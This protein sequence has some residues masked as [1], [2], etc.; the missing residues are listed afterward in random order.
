L[1]SVG[2]GNYDSFMAKKFWLA[3]ASTVFGAVLISGLGRATTLPPE[4]KAYDFAEAYYVEDG[5]VVIAP[6]A[7]GF[8][9]PHGVETPE[10]IRVMPGD[11]FVQFNPNRMLEEDYRFVRLD[12]SQAFFHERIFRYKVARD[13]R[14]RFCEQREQLLDT[15]DF[16]L[17]RFR[18]MELFDFVFTDIELH[19]GSQEWR[20]RQDPN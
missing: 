19:P 10:G 1:R 6:Y 2:W 9:C 4:L 7:H 17:S 14:G 3:C 15:D 11:R 16:Y 5:G 8:Y 18:G 12:G 20:T 13:A